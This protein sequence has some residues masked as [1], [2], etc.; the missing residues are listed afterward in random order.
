ML[1]RSRAFEERLL[2]QDRATNPLC[3]QIDPY[4][5]VQEETIFVRALQ[6]SKRWQKGHR[7][8]IRRNGRMVDRSTVQTQAER[9]N[10]Q[11]KQ[12]PG[13]SEDEI[14]IGAFVNFFSS[15]SSGGSNGTTKGY[16]DPYTCMGSMTACDRRPMSGN[17]RRGTVAMAHRRHRHLFDMH[18]TVRLVLRF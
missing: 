10:A 4:I 2:H 1:F 16:R 3:R 14:Q 13:R 15:G 5:Q 9:R 7:V 18:V 8:I 6:R 12:R 17:H 11:S